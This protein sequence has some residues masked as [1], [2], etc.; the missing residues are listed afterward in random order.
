MWSGYAHLPTENPAVQR[1]EG[2]GKNASK[3]EIY[4]LYNNSH[5]HNIFCYAD[6]DD[7]CKIIAPT[8]NDGD[9]FII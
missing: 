3:I 1:E 9:Y 7:K 5:K 2:G 8:V 6:V 4:Y